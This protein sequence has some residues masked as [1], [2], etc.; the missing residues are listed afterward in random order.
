M[1]R[2]VKV[3]LGVL[4]VAAVAAGSF[5]GGTVY[6][7]GQ[8]QTASPGTAGGPGQAGVPPAGANS[9]QTGGN[10]G[11][12]LFGQIKAIGEGTLTM[13][14]SSGKSVVVNITDTTLIQKQASVTLADLQP[15]ETVVISGSQGSDGSVTARMVQISSGEGF[16]QPGANPPSGA[17][18]SGSAG[19]TP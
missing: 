17:Q 4:L 2:V 13:T 15:G 5:Y 7:K 8:A 1:N 16:G 18:G 19:T 12:M 14:D 3:V 11:G 10:Q 9:G 6:G